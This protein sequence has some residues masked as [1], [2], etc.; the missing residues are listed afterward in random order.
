MKLQPNQTIHI[1]EYYP[2]YMGTLKGEATM[3]V[4]QLDSLIAAIKVEEDAK[5]GNGWEQ[6][7]KVA[8]YFKETQDVTFYGLNEYTT[9]AELKKIRDKLT[10]SGTWADQWS[11]GSIA[12]SVKSMKEA[13]KTCAA[14][15]AQVLAD[16]W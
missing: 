16:D 3:T 14:I 1:F 7:D 15:E 10:R 11:E 8:D 4:A 6:M 5:T 12:F 9:V 2:H 13:K